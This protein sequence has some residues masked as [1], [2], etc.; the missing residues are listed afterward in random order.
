MTANRFIALVALP[1]VLATGA[2]F[3]ARAIDFEELVLKPSELKLLYFAPETVE[4]S[5]PR[6][7][8]TRKADALSER[9][10]K[11]DFFYFRDESPKAGEAEAWTPQAAAYAAADPLAAKV[12]LIILNGKGNLAIVGNTVVMEGDTVGGM[13]VKRIEEDKV[14]LKGKDSRWVYMEGK[15]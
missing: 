2:F 15:R 9:Y 3:G 11:A 12:S 4:V 6:E 8:K 1:F 5:L 10:R 13:L 14:L 7:D